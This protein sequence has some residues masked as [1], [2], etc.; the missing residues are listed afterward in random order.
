MSKQNVSTQQS[1]TQSNA[2]TASQGFTVTKPQAEQSLDPFEDLMKS[3]EDV[4][5]AARTS[6]EAASQFARK[7][8]DVQASLKRKDREFKSTREIIEKLKMASG[9]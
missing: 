7:L 9:F 3:A 8:K 6:Y 4:K 2:S 1:S 5:T